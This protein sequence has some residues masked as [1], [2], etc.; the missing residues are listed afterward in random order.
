M[1]FSSNVTIFVTNIHL[2]SI[3]I[4]E[5]KSQIDSSRMIKEKSNTLTKSMMKYTQLR[6]L[7]KLQ[8]L[9]ISRYIKYV[10]YICY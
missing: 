1:K 9:L 3:N 6:L 10:I 2:H 4:D 7:I 8:I 5:V